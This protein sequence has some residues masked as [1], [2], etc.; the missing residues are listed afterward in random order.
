VNNKLSKNNGLL[1]GGAAVGLIAL[2][3]NNRFSGSQLAVAQMI[4]WSVFALGL[5]AVQV[6][7]T[8]RRNRQLGVGL[9]IVGLHSIGLFELRHLFPISSILIVI[10]GS[11]IESAILIA[12]YARVGQSIDPKGPFGLSEAEVQARE[13]RSRILKHPGHDRDLGSSG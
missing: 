9:A 4:V 8:L 3:L 6:H 7:K 11:G 12:L 10:I 2:I 13:K 5:A 1:A